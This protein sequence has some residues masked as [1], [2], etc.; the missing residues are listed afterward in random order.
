MTQSL[1]PNSRTSIFVNQVLPDQAFSAKVETTLPIVAERAMYRFPGNAATGVAGV[2]ETSK[3]WYFADGFTSPILDTWLLLQNTNT[4][5]A[6]VTVKLMGQNGEVTSVLLGMPPT[7]RRS[8]ELKQVLPN[9]DFGLTV[10]STQPIVAEKSMFWDAEPRG[11]AATE[12]AMQLATTWNLPEGETRAPFN[13]YIA[14]LNPHATT[15]SVHIDFQLLS[16]LVIGRDLTVGPTGKSSIF[17]DDIIDGANSARITTS[18]P[19]VVERTMFMEK[20]GVRGGH[21]TIGIK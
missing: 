2:N 14:I 1:G 21:N 5:P 9:G 19:S 16:G 11:A 15:M 12:G 17:V 18:L 13:Q 8:L 7:S 3:T 10:E 20:M 6:D 4:M